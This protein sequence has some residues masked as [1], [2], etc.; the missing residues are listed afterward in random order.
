MHRSADAETAIE[1]VFADLQQFAGSTSR[2]DDVT[3][4]IMKAL[5]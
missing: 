4:V 1:E 5:A 3:I 2:D